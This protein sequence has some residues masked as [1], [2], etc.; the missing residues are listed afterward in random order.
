VSGDG[1]LGPHLPRAACYRYLLALVGNVFRKRIMFGSDFADHIEMGIEVIV[2]AEF[3]APEQKN[4]LLCNNVAARS[5]GSTRR[6][7]SGSTR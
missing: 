3:L 4:N 5:S 7:S 1:C 6:A 2:A